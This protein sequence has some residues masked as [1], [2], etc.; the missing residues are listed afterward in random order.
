MCMTFNFGPKTITREH[1]DY[2]NWAISTCAIST[3]GRYDPKK[4]GQIILKQIKLIIEFP[5]ELTMFIP[6]ATLT[7]SNL[8]I[9]KG[10][11]RWSIT[12]YTAGGLFR[13]AYNRFKTDKSVLDRAD[14]EV[15]E[16]RMLDREVRW[17]ERVAHFCIIPQPV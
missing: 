6:S 5:P 7:H 4:S 17:E 16:Q 14:K 15:L 3:G 12:H 9:R 10:E 13:Y 11:R 1:K 8:P 2:L